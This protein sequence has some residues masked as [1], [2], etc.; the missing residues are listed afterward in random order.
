[1]AKRKTNRNDEGAAKATVLESEVRLL[2]PS[3]RT[4]PHVAVGIASAALVIAIVAA[5][6]AVDPHADAAFDAPKWLAVKLCAVVTAVAL[7]WSKSEQSR[8]T[9]TRWQL[10]VVLMIVIAA[11]WGAL[12]AALSSHGQSTWNALIG[13]SV[14]C[15]YILLGASR[16]LRGQAGCRLFG[17]VM[18]VGTA[19]AALSI[20]QAAGM[21][22]P[23]VA[24]QIGGRYPTGALLGNEGYVALFSALITV[25]S[26][27][28][29]FAAP[30]SAKTRWWLMGV[31]LVAI[32]AIIINRQ[33]TAAIATALGVAV[34]VALRFSYRWLVGAMMAVLIATVLTAAVP[35]LRAHSWASIPGASVETFQRLTTYR[36]GGWVAAEEM[37][38]ASPWMG[39]GPGSYAAEST[40]RRL[41]AEMRWQ[42]R[43][44]QPAGASFVY[45]H[46]EWLQLAAEYGVPAMLMILIAF[47]VVILRLVTKVPQAAGDDAERIMLAGVLV[48]GLVISVAWFPMQIPITAVVLLMAIGR[49]WRLIAVD[50]PQCGAR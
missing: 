43:F 29:M 34:V 32:A 44:L 26:I 23:I 28:I 30:V 48:T 16:L 8:L 35:V 11:L 42:Q 27:A 10:G 40:S 47:V 5:A 21:S 2:V 31:S 38:R 37:I 9:W 36:L 15:I 19:T 7:L 14:C 1:M 18:M 25:A 33:A 20:A 49:S 3:A 22:L 12:S 39:S 6:F 50:D 13:A 46:Q 24:A 4:A 41:D 45:A 17:C